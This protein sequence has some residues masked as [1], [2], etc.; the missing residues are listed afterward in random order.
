MKELQELQESVTRV[1]STEAA[2]R[3]R[4]ARIAMHA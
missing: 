2:A 4:L 1:G 3:G